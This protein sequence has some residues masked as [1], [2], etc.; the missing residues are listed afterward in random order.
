MQMIN[1]HRPMILKPQNDPLMRTED[2]ERFEVDMGL[3]KQMAEILQKQYPG[4][5]W[6][7]FADSKQGIVWVAIP[8]LM[9]P[10][11]RFVIHVNKMTSYP[12]MCKEL[13]EAAGQI[14]ERFK[15]KR[16]GFSL[17]DFIAARK[18]RINDHNTP[19]PE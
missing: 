6:A 17:L 10:S 11:L 3:A 12:E 13:R 2:R 18:N 5:Q 4:H 1:A 7:T 9:G 19:M 16:G 15:I 8:A 14:L